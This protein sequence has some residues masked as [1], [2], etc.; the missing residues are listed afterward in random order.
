MTYCDPGWSDGAAYREL[1]FTEEAIIEKPE[2]KCI[3][4][5]LRI[6]E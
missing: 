4:F 5:R 2:F 3:K 6:R 1:G